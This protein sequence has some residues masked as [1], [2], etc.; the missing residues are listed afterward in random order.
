MVS[1]YDINVT[2][3]SFTGNWDSVIASLIIYTLDNTSTYYI[4]GVK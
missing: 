2:R 4:N 3:N 1:W